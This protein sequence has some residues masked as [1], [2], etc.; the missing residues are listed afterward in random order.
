[1]GS[2]W[3]YTVPS[4]T[5]SD[6]DGDALTYTAS[7][8]PSWMTFTA[9]T[10]KFSGT[11]RTVGSWTITVTAHDGKGAT[12]SDSFVVTTPNAVPKLVSAIPDK[13]ATVG[14]A[15]SYTVPSATF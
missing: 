9:S 10:R 3:S 7:G 8:M 4:T 1:T 5:F 14:A 6:P 11:P 13:S 2:G 12:R 15:W